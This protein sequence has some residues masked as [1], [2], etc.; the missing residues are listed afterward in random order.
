[1]VYKK[2]ANMIGLIF[3]LIVLLVSSLACD[4][5]F[6]LTIEN[7]TAQVLHIYLDDI[8]LGEIEPDAQVTKNNAPGA[9]N[10]FLI[11]AKN[12]QGVTVF[13]KTLS[14]QQ[15]QH[16]KGTDDFKVVISTLENIPES[17]ENISNN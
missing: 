3:L 9:I 17:S 6:T 7:K 4:R 13:S 5:Y 15:M 16:S 11:V 8:D 12:P 14:R 10:H 1:M 2:T